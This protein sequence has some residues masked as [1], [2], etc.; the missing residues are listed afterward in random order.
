MSDQ[1]NIATGVAD[2]YAGEDSIV[3]KIVEPRKTKSKKPSK[4]NTKE[5]EVV[6]LLEAQRVI[7]LANVLDPDLPPT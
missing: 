4:P 6:A 3:I 7:N 2:A 1:S 5:R